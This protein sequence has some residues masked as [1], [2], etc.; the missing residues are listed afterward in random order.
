VKVPGYTETVERLMTLVVPEVERMCARVVWRE[1]T[2]TQKK[3][4][5][6]KDENE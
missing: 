2:K 5:S 3:E 1:K 4:T 6:V